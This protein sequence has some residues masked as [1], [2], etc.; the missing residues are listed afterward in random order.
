MRSLQPLFLFGFLFKDYCKRGYVPNPPFYRPTHPLCPVRYWRRV[1]LVQLLLL[2]PA[3]LLP[4]H[5]MYALPGVQ[6]WA[7]LCSY[8]TCPTLLRGGDAAVRRV[9]LSAAMLLRWWAFFVDTFIV[10]VGYTSVLAI[11]HKDINAAGTTP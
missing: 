8:T 5:V 4:Y 1:Q 7:R 11:S 6:Y 2:F 3:R 9:I 10:T